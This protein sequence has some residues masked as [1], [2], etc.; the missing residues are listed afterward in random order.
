[1]N[2]DAV[3]VVENVEKKVEEKVNEEKP[4]YEVISSIP[5]RDADYKELEECIK[6]KVE[7][8]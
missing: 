4:N 8:M 3:Y 6:D 7:N 5:F 2:S 1:M